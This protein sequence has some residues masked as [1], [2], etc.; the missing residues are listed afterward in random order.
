ML[1][2]GAAAVEKVGDGHEKVTYYWKEPKEKN[3]K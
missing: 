3:R 1:V 2:W